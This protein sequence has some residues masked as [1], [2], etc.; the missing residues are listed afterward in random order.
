MIKGRFWAVVAIHIKQNILRKCRQMKPNRLPGSLWWRP[1]QECLIWEKWVR[2]GVNWDGLPRA[3][4]NG[5]NLSGS[6]FHSKLGWRSDA[7][8]MNQS[9]NYHRMLGTSNALMPS[10][11][12]SSHTWGVQVFG[13]GHLT[14]SW[15]IVVS[16]C[17]QFVILWRASSQKKS[18]N[19]LS[20]YE[21]L[22]LY[23]L[24]C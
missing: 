21:D 17:V 5:G 9:P 12:M 23:N 15:G 24:L 22:R 13:V 18:S 10:S 7:H 1:R 3:D 6:M 11:L 16:Q 8:N 19:I 2:P 20:M 14:R 4:L